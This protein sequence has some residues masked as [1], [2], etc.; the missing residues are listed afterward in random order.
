MPSCKK[1]KNKNNKKRSAKGRK[2]SARMRSWVT[3][4]FV[5]AGI[6]ALAAL[7]LM[8]I[9]RWEYSVYPL[10]YTEE[11]LTA[12]KKYGLSPALVASVINT[13]SGFRADAESHAGAVGLMQIMPQTAEWIAWRQG[14]EHHESALT[15]VSYNI[16]MGCY[17]LNY[18]LQRYSGNIEY[19][20]AA[21]NAGFG[22]VDSWLKDGTRVTAEGRLI[23]PYA[24]TENYVRKVMVGIEKYSKLY[25]NLS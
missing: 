22:A 4:L 16:D 18:L 10:E 13:E 20:L 15:G 8:G 12:S 2:S 6:I 3:A 17:L 24:E 14:S 21:Y 19:A 23:I 5:C 7:A 25:K 9:N 1:G 11:I